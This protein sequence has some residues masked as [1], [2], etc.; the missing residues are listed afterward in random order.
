MAVDIHSFFFDKSGQNKTDTAK[1]IC[2]LTSE[3][4]D[5]AIKDINT[6]IN[7]YQTNAE[8]EY[9]QEKYQKYAIPH[10]ARYTKLRDMMQKRKDVLDS[11][12][13]D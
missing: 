1:Q 7:N 8:E 10:I 9:S 2:A 6:Y 11:R 12:S 13:E 4:L 5:D 3:E